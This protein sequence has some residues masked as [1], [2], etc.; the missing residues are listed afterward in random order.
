MIIVTGGMGFI[1]SNLVRALNLQNRSDIVVVDDLT[2]G[3]KFVNLATASIADYFDR[4][5]FQR[6]F[7][8]D[9][10]RFANTEIVYHLGAC[11]DTTEWNG[12][13]MLETNFAYSKAL[14]ETCLARRIPFVY[15]SS[16]AVYGLASDCIEE[17]MRESPLNVYAY[18]KL[19]FDQYVRRTL[20]SAQSSVIGLRYFNVY[21]PGEQHKGR[22][23]SVGYHFNRQLNDDGK[24]RLFG[25]SH[26]VG[27]GE[28][29]RDFVHVDDAINLTLWC[30]EQSQYSGILNC[31]TGT[32]AT[33]N[34]VAEAIVAWHG[35][36]QIDYIPFPDELIEA[37]QSHTCANLGNLRCAGYSHEF[38]SVAMG[39]KQYLDWLNG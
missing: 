16:A 2:D 10:T 5:E 17:P 32:A 34:A 22:M 3:R 19:L 28:Q 36:G 12:R 31:G 33:F 1:G 26:G 20:P 23:A 9:E 29:R 25:A 27:P 39:I 6:R 8:A 7:E 11:S 30:G 21:G 14:L 37:Y 13:Y 4:A 38:R 18:S 35:R 24:V 15:A